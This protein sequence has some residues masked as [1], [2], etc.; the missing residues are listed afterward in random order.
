MNKVLTSLA[1]AVLAV[2]S[3]GPASA[4]VIEF[5]ED[6]HNSPTSPRT[7][8][9]NTSA[10]ESRFLSGLTGERVENFE[11][12]PACGSPA[13]CSPTTVELNFSGSAGVALK[14]TLSGGGGY[15]RSVPAGTSESGRYSVPAATSTNFWRAEAGT[16]A[17]GD[18]F[19]IVFDADI[20]AFG[21]YGVDIGDFGGRVTL[22]LL[23]G[24]GAMIRSLTVPNTDGT[25][26]ADGDG[27]PDTPSDGSVLYYG[28]RA[29]S[30]S[31]VF[32]GIRFR[33]SATS[34]DVFAFD[35]FT[36]VDACQAG[37]C[38]GPGVPE[39][40]SLALAGLAL[41]ALGAL[42]RRA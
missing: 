14:A 30:L 4:Y 37:L 7:S 3:A 35:N 41:L 38:T 21:F 36:V 13:S 9:P 34:I 12:R 19:T 10:A 24:S 28:L 2:A 5:A 17:A 22:E 8:L 25:I 1:V 18:P 33:T 15:V 6:L 32:R 40:G 26:D 39:P 29:E 31:E 20:A 16:A 23:D 11:S 27:N 42:R